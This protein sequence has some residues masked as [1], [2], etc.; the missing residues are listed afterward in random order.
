M[1]SMGI[2]Q[3]SAYQWSIR[4]RQITIKLM[5]MKILLDSGHGINTPDKRSPDGKLREYAWAREIAKRLEGA[6]KAK[7]FDAE[8]IVT[9]ETD[10]SI[11]ER[12]RRVNSI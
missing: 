3:L 4:I 8:R 9:E 7:G 11:N 6:L 12:V 2:F 10:I 1:V 5:T